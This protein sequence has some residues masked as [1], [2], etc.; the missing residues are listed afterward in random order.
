MER[1]PHR[2]SSGKSRRI[3]SKPAK[4]RAAKAT[5]PVGPTEPRFKNIELLIAG[6]GNITIGAM[7]PVECAATAADEDICYAMLVRHDGESLL[8]LLSRLDRSIAEA[9]D[10]NMPIDE[11]NSP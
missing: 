6:R 1:R 9:A 4:K 3:T 11:V 10:N 8:E 5:A 2:V 7:G